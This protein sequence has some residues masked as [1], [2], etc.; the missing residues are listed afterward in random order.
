[1]NEAPDIMEEMWTHSLGFEIKSIHIKLNDVGEVFEEKWNLS[2]GFEISLT[3]E[4]V[5]PKVN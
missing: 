1:M 5:S 4:Q 3:E 2:L